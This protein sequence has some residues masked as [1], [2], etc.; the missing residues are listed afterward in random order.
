MRLP[1]SALR[2]R[3]LSSRFLVALPAALL[4]GG[5]D[6]GSNLTEPVIDNDADPAISSLKVAKVGDIYLRGSLKAAASDPE[7]ELDNVVIDWG[8]G[9]TLTVT[10]DFDAIS[11]THDYDRDGK[12]D[13]TVTATDLAGNRVSSRGSLSL[14]PVPHACADIKVVGA[15]FNVHPDYKGA[16]VEIKVVGNT[17]H[18]YNLSTT[19]NRIEVILPIAGI[20]GQAKVIMTS[21]F[22]R[23]KGKSW[24][25]VDVKGCTLLSVCTNSLGSKRFTW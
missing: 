5:C 15:C 7:G 24:L 3:Q 22:S 2:G 14:D 9:S 23:T 16:D 8:D 18:K 21:R 20:V 17:V 1:T 12:Y 11:K 10:A 6:A 4:L 19:K 13:V 25:K